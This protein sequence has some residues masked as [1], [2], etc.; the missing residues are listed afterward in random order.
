M[1]NLSFKYKIVIVVVLFLLFAIGMFTYGYNILF[2]KNQVLAD[3]ASQRRLEYD[4]L[5]REQLAF[6][7][8]KKDL[9]TLKGEPY[10]PENLFSKDTKVVKE[11]QVLEDQATRYELTLN[12][13]ISGTTKTASKATG[14][15]GELYTVPYTVTLVGAFEN[16][17]NYVQAT[18]HLPYIS[19]TKVVNMNAM[20][21]NKV[22]L[23]MN[24][25]FYIKK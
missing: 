14:V 13:S 8:G 15:S 22:R 10:P 25:D 18:E 21:D 5:Q 23:I 9:T 6:D 4:V 1:K 11:I 12:L 3:A 17:I 2:S 7:Q 20:D 19:Y 16:I 24:S